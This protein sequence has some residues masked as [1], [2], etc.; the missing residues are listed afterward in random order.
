[1]NL[2]IYPSVHP[3]MYLSTCLCIYLS[4]PISLSLSLYLP[5][6]LS[7]YLCIYLSINTALPTDV[8]SNFLRPVSFGHSLGLVHQQSI[9]GRLS[10]RKHQLRGTPC[11]R[12]DLL[13]A[14]GFQFARKPRSWTHACLRTRRFPSST[15]STTPDCSSPFPMFGVW[16]SSA[17]GSLFLFYS[18]LLQSLWPAP[19]N[20]PAICMWIQY[21]DRV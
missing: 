7:I 1:M 15:M 3:S 19:P 20:K 14:F 5:V 8:A 9:C 6:C 4:L 2:S 12:R 16:G 13:I 11:R 21:L 10:K 17:A 18:S